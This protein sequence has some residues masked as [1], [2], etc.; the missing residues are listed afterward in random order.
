MVGLAWSE[1]PESYAGGRVATGSGSHAGQVRG[2]D[3]DKKIY[4]G[5]LATGGS[6]LGVKR[7][8]GAKLTTYSSVEVNNVYELYP[9]SP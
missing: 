4:V 6:F 5:L 9:V 7:G 3:P 1:G 8:W 2:D